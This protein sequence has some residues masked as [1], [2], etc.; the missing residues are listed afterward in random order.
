MEPRIHQCVL[1]G[2]WFSS[3]ELL[4]VQLVDTVVLSMGL[5]SL[6]APSVL[7]LT[8][9]S[10]TPGSVQWLAAKHSAFWKLL[11]HFS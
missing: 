11:H 10:G 1:F 9:P 7:P 6:S 2:W 4:V 5:P 8:L 3:W